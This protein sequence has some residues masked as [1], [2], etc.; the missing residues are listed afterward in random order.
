MLL[1]P[2]KKCDVWE[3]S[4]PAARAA[5][6]AAAS[7]S[8]W[9]ANVFCHLQS[10]HRLG[11]R[12]VGTQLCCFAAGQLSWAISV[13][14]GLWSQVVLSV[15]HK[16]LILGSIRSVPGALSFVKPFT[17]AFSLRQA[18]P[19]LPALRLRH[20]LWEAL[21]P[22]DLLAVF[23][24]LCSSRPLLSPLVAVTGPTSVYSPDEN[25]RHCLSAVGLCVSLHKAALPDATRGDWFPQPAEVN[26]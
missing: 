15:Y 20:F 9:H 6:W 1:F 24:P 18:K 17:L 22:S 12:T 14:T 10:C 25:W 11:A 26:Q 19:G 2:L 5:W 13:V 21:G 7:R 23:S 8:R 4:L 16:D 3:A